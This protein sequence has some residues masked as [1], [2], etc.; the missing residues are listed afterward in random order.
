MRFLI[1]GVLAV[2]MDFAVYF[3]LLQIITQ[4]PIPLAKTISYLSG[5]VISFVGHRNFVFKADHH[6]PQHQIL[7]F[8]ILYGGSLVANNLMN[9]L[10]LNVTHIKVLAWFLSIC[11]STSIN[12]LGMKLGVFKKND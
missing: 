1:V 3:G 12:Y 6:K 11:T 4:I 7:P 8:V 10:V 9:A 5:M 2:A